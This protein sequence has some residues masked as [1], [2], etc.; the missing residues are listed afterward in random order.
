MSTKRKHVVR[1]D[2]PQNPAFDQRLA[3]ESDIDLKVCARAGPEA[4]A[5]ADGEPVGVSASEA[6]GSASADDLPF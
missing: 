3:H 1:F 2:L 5:P 6:D 4:A